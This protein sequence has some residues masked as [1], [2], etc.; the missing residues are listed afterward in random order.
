MDFLYVSVSPWSF[1]SVLFLLLLLLLF[2]RALSAFDRRHEGCD[3]EF[4]RL[5]GDENP[6]LERLAMTIKYPM[7]NEID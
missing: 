4:R 1:P 2:F 3:E 7:Q 6:T 5:D